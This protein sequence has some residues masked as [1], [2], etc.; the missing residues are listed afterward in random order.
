MRTFILTAFVM[1][2]GAALFALATVT[3]GQEDSSDDGPEIRRYSD[4]PEIPEE[5]RRQKREARRLYERLMEFKNDP[6]FLDVGLGACCRYAE[7]EDE[8]EEL[9]EKGGL[10]L[11]RVNGSLNLLS[12]LAIDY[13]NTGG[14]ETEETRR[15]RRSIESDFKARAD[16]SEGQGVVIEEDYRFES[17]KQVNAYMRAWNENDQQKM[18]EILG[19]TAI[20][21][22]LL[23]RNTVVEGPLDTAKDL[24]ERWNVKVRTKEHGIVW[25]RDGIV[26]FR[27]P[28]DD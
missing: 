11:F 18:D 1:L 10:D 25:V 20:G 23:Y 15:M 16:I 2:S 7:W 27:M 28:E 21:C 6:L 24:R 26:A 5:V 12:F 3:H 17:M 4:L 13:L 19:C 8:V 9:S 14:R 22:P